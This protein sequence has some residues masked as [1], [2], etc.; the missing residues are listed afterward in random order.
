MLLLVSVLMVAIAGV[1]VYA[2]NFMQKI[3][4]IVE[5]GDAFPHD[6]LRPRAVHV[7]G[8]A[9]QNILLLGSDTRGS[10]SEDI[11]ETKG[12]RSDAMMVMHIP[13]DRQSI[14]VMSLMRAFWVDIMGHG[15]AK[16]NAA[17]AYCGV[18]LAFQI[19][20]GIIGALIDHVVIID[21]QDFQGVTDA[22]GGVTIDNPKAF[23]GTNKYHF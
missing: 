23:E 4:N 12:T 7:D 16:L 20:E 9:P 3:D 1:G 19:I 14:Q 18:K 15:K 21:I 6:I 22:L 2:F 11:K 8:S 5:I 10:I 17:M 13:A